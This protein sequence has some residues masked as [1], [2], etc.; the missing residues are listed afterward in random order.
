[1]IFFVYPNEE[2]L[3]FVVKDT[4]G[5]WPITIKIASFK[6]PVTLLK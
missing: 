5:A 2:S 1:M 6:E 3:F 4:T